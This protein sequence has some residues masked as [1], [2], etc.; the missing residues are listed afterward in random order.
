MIDVDLLA[1]LFVLVAA[2]RFRR[3]KAPILFSPRR[4]RMRLT[5]AGEMHS[6][7]AICLPVKRWRRNT[8][9][10]STTGCGVG[11]CNRCGREL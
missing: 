2:G 6:C 3:L 4:L 5:L 1:G 7:A 8:A 10:C 9:T 11:L